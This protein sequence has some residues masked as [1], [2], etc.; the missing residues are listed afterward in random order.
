MKRLGRILASVC[1]VLLLAAL[2]G[3]FLVP[4]PPLEGTV[5]PEELADPDGR[6]IDLNGLHVHYKIRGE[7]EPA[8]VLLH[9]FGASLFSWREVIP[10]LGVDHTV[11]AF[12]RPAF[13]LTSRPL[14][15]EWQ[16][17][18]PYRA[19]AQV[20]L[21]I[22]L[23]DTLGLE[24]A[25]LVGNSAGGTIAVLTALSHP[26]RVE[27]LVLVDPSIYSTGGMPGWLSPILRTPQMRRIGPLIARRIQGWGI[28]FARSAWHDP[29]RNMLKMP[30]LKEMNRHYACFFPC[31]G[32][33][34]Q[35][36]S[37]ASQK[38]EDKSPLSFL[39]MEPDVAVPV[40]V[41]QRLAPWI[42]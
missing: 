39:R 32:L 30:T 37:V 22:A 34:Q 31:G 19:D 9:G 28:D 7:G 29:S 4:V 33:F 15:G 41:F 13:G 5:P 27:A 1:G 20:A 18:S 42:A 3:P 2:V 26:E 17:E 10:P 16:G 11:V 23:M 21:T 35:P 36:A 12:D 24:R 40:A 14:P 25:V 38:F 8:L 6:F